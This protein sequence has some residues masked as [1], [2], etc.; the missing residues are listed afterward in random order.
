MAPWNP[1][2]GR[3]FRAKKRAPLGI[4]LSASSCRFKAP[5]TF[6]DAL[7]VGASV[8]SVDASTGTLTL[9]HTIWSHKAQRVAA[10]GTGEVVLFNYVANER[11]RGPVHPELLAALAAVDARAAART[12]EA[13]RALSA[14]GVAGYSDDA[15]AELLT[16]GGG[17]R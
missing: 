2:A 9:A 11:A 12:D 4:I 5:L 14:P 16:G 1:P 13:I 6:P 3:F 15:E 17:W 7:C 8:V 10:T